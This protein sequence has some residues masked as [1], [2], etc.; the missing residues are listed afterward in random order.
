MSLIVE[1]GA[2]LT[3]NTVSFESCS[4][5]N[6]GGL[7]INLSGTP[8][9]AFSSVTFTSCTTVEEGGIGTNVFVT[10]S[11]IDPFNTS[12][13]YIKT[14]W[15]SLIGVTEFDSTKECVWWGCVS[16]SVYDLSFSLLHLLFYPSNRN[17]SK[18]SV[19][20][21][22]NGQQCSVDI[23]T[24]GWSDIP[25]PTV[26]A[27]IVN[28]V[29]VEMAGTEYS[30]DEAKGT[31]ADVALTITG[32]NNTAVHMTGGLYEVSGSKDS[33]F[34]SLDVSLTDGFFVHS[35][36]SGISTIIDV[37]I[38]SAIEV[39]HSLTSSCITSTSGGILLSN[40]TISFQTTLTLSSPLIQSGSASSERNAGVRT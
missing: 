40:V 35:S 12:L 33:E 10:A 32:K 13:T 4:A 19:S 1:E 20:T 16:T 39:E 38:T 6:G 7:S 21:T 28:A 23:P 5:V 14:Q 11:S 37:C 22:V 18:L 34:R 26:T 2:N 9:L 17:D 3:L 25:C 8:S 24:C 31:I 29:T 30:T 27:A 36:S 15:T